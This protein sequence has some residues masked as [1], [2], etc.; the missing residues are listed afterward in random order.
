MV[1]ALVSGGFAGC[2]VSSFFFLRT[3]G[4]AVAD[5]GASAGRGGDGLVL[6]GAGEGGQEYSAGPSSSLP[7]V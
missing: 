1:S 7:I 2:G 6:A 3:L 4:A 5:G